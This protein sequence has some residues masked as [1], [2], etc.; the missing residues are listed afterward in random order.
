MTDQPW[1]PI[2]GETDIAFSWFRYYVELPPH[3]RSYERVFDD[4]VS[5][6]SLVA[7]RKAATKY[8]WRERAVQYDAWIAQQHDEELARLERLEAIKWSKRRIEL[9]ER[10]YNAAGKLM[11]RVDRLID[12]LDMM[13]STPL[14]EKQVINRDDG[15]E[16]HLHPVGWRVGDMSSLMRTI[17]IA[18]RESE[19]LA[20]IATETTTSLLDDT[21]DD[22]ELWDL[23]DDLLEDIA[24]G[25]LDPRTYNGKHKIKT[26]RMMRG[27]VGSETAVEVDNDQG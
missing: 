27:S 15:T 22:V 10:S 13:V 8:R 17:T 12:K 2:K 1:Q 16:I 20:R 9:R 7:V 18:A 11:D 5:E 21:I 6:N 4:F 23:P 14:H 3:E 26:V 24:Q 25:R 19:K